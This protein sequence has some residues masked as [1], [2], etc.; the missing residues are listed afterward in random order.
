MRILVVVDMQ[1]DFV[2]GPLGSDEAIAARGN[3]VKLIKELGNTDFIIFTRDTHSAY[4]YFDSQEGRKLPVAHCIKNTEGWRVCDE[5]I[6]A[7]GPHAPY[8]EFFDKPNFGSIELAYEIEEL[9]EEEWDSNKG[10]ITIE[11]CGVCTD[12]CV[13]SNALILKAFLPEETIMVHKTCCAGTTPENHEAAL[14]TMASCQIEVV[15]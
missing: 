3:I 12:I 13:V 4:D 2:T 10:N 5:L 8:I 6:R 9:I 11:L 14:K 15:D 7:A 1:N